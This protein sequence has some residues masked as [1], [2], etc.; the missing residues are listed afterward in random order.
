MLAGCLAKVCRCTLALHSATRPSTM[1]R[2]PVVLCFWVLMALPSVEMSGGGSGGDAFRAGGLPRGYEEVDLAHFQRALTDLWSKLTTR[3]P[4]ELAGKMAL[5]L[6]AQQ[7]TRYAQIRGSRMLSQE[8]CLPPE[9]R[10]I[11]RPSSW[12]CRCEIGTS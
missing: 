6:G 2:R 4:G 11:V 7:L 9:L 3:D 8:P 5:M 10:S 1:D 12:M